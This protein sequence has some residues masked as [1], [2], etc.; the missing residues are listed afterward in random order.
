MGADVL[1]ESATA[2]FK[3]GTRHFD[4][5][6][7]KEWLY[8][9]AD[10]GGVTAAGYVVLID[11]SYNADMIDL[12]NSATGFGQPVG[13]AGLAVTAS[14]YFWAQVLGTAVVR[15]AASAAANV[16][17]NTTATAGQLDDDATSGAE[18]VE[19]IALTTAN[20][21]AAATAAAELLQPRVRNTI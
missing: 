11:E 7:G 19:G 16:Q 4:P 15:V 2:L 13:V 9:K 20:G 10:A 5:T 8:V 21:G 6:T 18:V 17:L 12:T 14:Y 3:V 1:N